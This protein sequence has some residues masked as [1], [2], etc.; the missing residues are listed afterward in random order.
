MATCSTFVRAIKRRVEEGKTLKTIADEL[1]DVKLP[2]RKIIRAIKDFLGE[3]YLKEHAETLGYDV[4]MADL[5]RKRIPH[6]NIA[7]TAE[8]VLITPG[9]E[10]PTKLEEEPKEIDNP[11]FI[12]ADPVPEPDPYDEDMEE[13]FSP[14]PQQIFDAPTE[15]DPVPPEE[16]LARAVRALVN[17]YGKQVVLEA[18]KATLQ[19]IEASNIPTTPDNNTKSSSIDRIKPKLYISQEH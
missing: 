13:D 16:E 19:T 3:D 8:G 6:Q 12:E 7:A 11:E 9:Q 17:Q 4:E 1:C 14:A 2:R 18:V 5:A 15:C 10:T